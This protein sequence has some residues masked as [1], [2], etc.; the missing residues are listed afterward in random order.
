M[1]R[2]GPLALP[3]VQRS[4]VFARFLFTSWWG[5]RMSSG[6]V[7]SFNACNFSVRMTSRCVLNV[8]GEAASF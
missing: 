2:C 1:M 8:S 5:R 6:Y 3:K 7:A 4:Q